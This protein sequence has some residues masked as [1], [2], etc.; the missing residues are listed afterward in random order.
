MPAYCEYRNH[1]VVSRVDL[2]HYEDAAHGIPFPGVDICDQCLLEHIRQHY[3]GSP[4]ERAILMLRPEL[5]DGL[6]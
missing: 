4:I 3:P 2:S 1:D 5:K 6:L